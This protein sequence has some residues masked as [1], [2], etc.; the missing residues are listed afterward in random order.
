MA[1]LLTAGELHSFALPEAIADK[2]EKV[3]KIELKE[4]TEKEGEE[5]DEAYE[6]KLKEAKRIKAESD[7]KEIDAYNIPYQMLNEKFSKMHKEHLAK[8]SKGIEKK[9]TVKSRKELTNWNEDSVKILNMAGDMIENI[10][11]GAKEADAARV[12]R[13]MV[14][15]NAWIIDKLNNPKQI[16]K[17]DENGNEITVNEDVFQEIFANIENEQRGIFE[18]IR[19]A[20]TNIASSYKK[21]GGKVS[22]KQFLSSEEMKKV[23][24]EAGSNMIKKIDA[25]EKDAMDKMDEVTTDIFDQVE[26]MG[27]P[28][29]FDDEEEMSNEEKHQADLEKL[30]RMQNQ[31]LYDRNH[32]QGKFI[33]QLTSGYYKNA[34]P[35]SRRFMLSYIV[36]DIKK[37]TDDRTDRQLGGQYF[38]S[39]MKGAG[40][41]MQ[42]MMQGIPERM[43]VPEMRDAIMVVKSNL[44]HIDPEYKQQM[45]QKIMDD[46]AKWKKGKKVSSNKVTEIKEIKSLG[47]ASVAETF[48][49]EVKGL[50]KE[51]VN[52]VIKIKRN[53]A[54]DRMKEE[55]PFIK[56][57]SM[58][59]DMT[60]EEI[61]KYE[62]S[63]DKKH[64][65]GVTES[66]FIA[67]FSAIEKEFDF[68]NEI[69]N[70]K[71]GEKYYVSAKRHVDTVKINDKF[72]KDSDYIVM[73]LAEGKTVDSYMQEVRDEIDDTLSIYKSETTGGRPMLTPIGLG[74]AYSSAQRLADLIPQAKKN[75]NY[76]ADLAY[77]WIRQALFMGSEKFHHG[78]M[79]SGNIMISEKGTTVLDY[80]NAAVLSEAKVKQILGMMSAVLVGR[81]DFYVDAFDELL[82]ISETE[83]EARK[84]TSEYVGYSRMSL[85]QKRELEKRLEEVF[86]LGTAEDTGKKVLLTLTIAQEVGIKLPKEIQNFSQCQQRLENSVM[87]TKELVLDIGRTIDSIYA[88]PVDPKFR[89]SQDPMLMFSMQMNKRKPGGK[90]YS[91]DEAFEKVSREFDCY[92][93][94]IAEERVDD[95]ARSERNKKEF[96]KK[97]LCEKVDIK[98]DSFTKMGE[99]LPEIKEMF[100]KVRECLSNNE[101]PPKELVKALESAKAGMAQAMI[102]TELLVQPSYEFGMISDYVSKAF[103][104]EHGYRLDYFERLVYFIEDYIPKLIKTSEKY[105]AYIALLDKN[106]DEKG[107][108]KMTKEVKEARDELKIAVRRSQC[109][110]TQC[111]LPPALTRLREKLGKID[112]PAVKKKLDEEINYMLASNIGDLNSKYVAYKK[113]FEKYNALDKDADEKVRADEKQKLEDATDDFLVEYAE[114]AIYKLN[115]Y[116]NQMTEWSELHGEKKIK[117][118][119]DLPDFVEK[120][121]EVVENHLYKATDKLGFKYK[122]ELGKMARQ[123]KLKEL[124]KT[125]E[126]MTKEQQEAFDKA[127]AKYKEDLEKYRADREKKLLKLEEAYQAKHAGKVADADKDTSSGAPQAAQTKKKK[128][129]LF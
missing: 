65:V 3:L 23:L 91:V 90:R 24:G 49:C 121:G 112:D 80:G 68:E 86:K 103:S 107:K 54:M 122:A 125:G 104:N 64:K 92:T 7:A 34:A 111:T 25:F 14:A 62:E 120:M 76:V 35:K 97:Y 31:L 98:N 51:P 55:L 26:G 124:S 16:K 4:F 9:V 40:P 8:M 93:V 72:K 100:Y 94:G 32:G 102:N 106:T 15:G 11:P 115:E 20:L 53:D 10:L 129:G 47:A 56:K 79:H 30:D 52:V 43:V 78:D 75:Q 39:A 17:T 96:E 105:E 82:G 6:N 95:L 33:E 118:D 45:F 44:R 58:Y 22:L 84:G 109:A 18:E 69:N 41:L 99:K 74:F 71:L 127:E 37:K 63:P 73:N 89:D 61:K 70:A 2:L 116:K 1:L 87:E 29:L 128:W 42:K 123:A 67:Q 57:C 110:R 5:R 12:I 101:E 46:T 13:D 113:Q 83:D 36:K 126:K 88:L 21:A 50:E 60:K 48:L 38:A 85:A 77:Q 28:S 108:V 117:R 27:I 59:A 66:G 19:Y 81:T 114:Q 119:D